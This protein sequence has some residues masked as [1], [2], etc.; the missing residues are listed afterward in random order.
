MIYISLSYTH[1]CTC[2]VEIPLPLMKPHGPDRPVWSPAGPGPIA[3][4]RG[5]E[6]ADPVVKS[7]R[8][9]WVK[10]PSIGRTRQIGRNSKIGRIG[11]IGKIGESRNRQIGKS[12]KSAKSAKLAKSIE[13]AQR[14]RV[15]P[16]CIAHNTYITRP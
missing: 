2:T 10:I 8:A 5:Q 14:Q 15:E 13:F 9:E 3:P 12:A 16:L 6:A 7:A 1:T 4:G 11:R